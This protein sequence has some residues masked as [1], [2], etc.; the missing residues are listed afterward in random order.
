M[1][2]RK[3][4]EGQ[5]ND[6]IKYIDEALHEINDCLMFTKSYPSKGEEIVDK[7]Q[8]LLEKIKKYAFSR[9]RS[10]ILGETYPRSMT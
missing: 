1:H 10:Y 2:I 8:Q 3:Y 6:V 5:F 4:Y 9:L 7:L